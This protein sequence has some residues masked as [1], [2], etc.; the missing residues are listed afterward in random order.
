MVKQK[1][2]SGAKKRI[3]K[4]GSGKFRMEKAAKRHLLANKSH[5][6]KKLGGKK[7][8][9]NPSNVRSLQQMFIK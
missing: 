9:V 2:H 7:I 1:S 6:Q 8:V 3:K 4:T 5:R